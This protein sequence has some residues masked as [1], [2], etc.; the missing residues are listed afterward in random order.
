MQAAPTPRHPPGVSE[1][2]APLQDLLQLLCEA[3]RK[4]AR[5]FAPDARLEVQELDEVAR[6]LRGPTT[7][8]EFFGRLPRD[9]QYR[10]LDCVRHEDEHWVRMVFVSE[11]GRGPVERW[12]CQVAGNRLC[13]LCVELA[14]SMSP[15]ASDDAVIETNP[16]RADQLPDYYFG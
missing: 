16:L 3:P 15:D 10:I 2:P 8:A 11:E 6:R 13:S 1:A 4:A 5:V 14:A 12:R 7:I 9:G